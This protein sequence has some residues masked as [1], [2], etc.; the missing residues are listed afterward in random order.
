MIVAID[1]RK[2]AKDIIGAYNLLGQP[3]EPSCQGVVIIVFFDGTTEKVL[4]E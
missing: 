2:E 4:N 1:N 3:V